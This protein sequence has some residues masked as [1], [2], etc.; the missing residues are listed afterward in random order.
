M[1]KKIDSP[2]GTLLLTAQGG[3]LTRIDFIGGG[4]ITDET[5]AANPP[6]DGAGDERDAAVLREAAR[7]LSEYFPG[8]RKAFTL[9]LDPEGTAFQ[10]RVW[11]ALQEIPY[12]ETRTYA[13]IAAAI[14]SPRACR[15]VGGANGRNPLP[16][17]VPCHRVVAASGLGG[18]SGGLDKK[19][20]LLQIERGC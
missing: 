3:A 1:Q 9:P 2:F 8:K 16:I 14:G 20:L 17:V 6:E 4:E 11:R 19:I 15:A 12:G 18:Y 13:Q 5:G 7:Q 10:R